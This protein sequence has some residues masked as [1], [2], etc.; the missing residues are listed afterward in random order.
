M[1]E[2]QTR[3]TP[4]HIAIIM[5]GNGRWAQKRGLDRVYGHIEG[6]ES[7]RKT[8]QGC[9]DTGVKYLTIYA[10]S[11]ENWGRPSDEVNALM[12]LLCES[13]LKETPML[14]GN[15]VR[16]RFIGDLEA[17]SPNVQTS[18]RAS[19]QQTSLNEKLTL[20]IAV[21]YSSRWEITHAMQEIA[22]KIKDGSLSPQD[23]TP[24]LI[25]ENLTTR[26][27]PDPDLL[28][29]TSGECRLSNFLLW[30][31]SYSELYFTD[32]LW[33]DFDA[34]ALQKAIQEYG[35]RQRRYGTLK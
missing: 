13:T 8:V 27:I 31:L 30:Q 23:I 6:V 32:I 14:N 29:R 22:T 2:P 19:E 34:T 5:D 10:F 7:L 25:S 20:I 26:G 16:M 11:T 15:G 9:L 33:P 17:L 21:N 35:Q 1:N 18:I 28:I 12:E 3:A 4:Q 24:E